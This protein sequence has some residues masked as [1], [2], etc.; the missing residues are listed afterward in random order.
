MLTSGMVLW[1]QQFPDGSQLLKIDKTITKMHVSHVVE[2]QVW[3]NNWRVFIQKVF[4][5]EMNKAKRP[6]VNVVC[7]CLNQDEGV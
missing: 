6:T 4:V 3:N 1:H 2:A 7:C 5:M